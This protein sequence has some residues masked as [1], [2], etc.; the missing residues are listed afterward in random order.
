M[1]WKVYGLNAS[2]R[3][4]GKRIKEVEL[5]NGLSRAVWGE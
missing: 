1:K 4:E 5:V 2:D 3:N